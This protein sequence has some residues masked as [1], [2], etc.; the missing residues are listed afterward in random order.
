[1]QMSKLAKRIVAHAVTGSVMLIVSG[2]STILGLAPDAIVDWLFGRE[3][4]EKIAKSVF[5]EMTPE[6]LRTAPERC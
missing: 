2:V 5:S 3:N 6:H 4:V 1:M